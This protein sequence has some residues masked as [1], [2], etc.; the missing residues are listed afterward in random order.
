M[1]QEHIRNIA[2][3]FEGKTMRFSSASW[4]GLSWLLLQAL[5][6]RPRFRREPLLDSGLE[7]DILLHPAGIYFGFTQSKS[8]RVQS[9]LIATTTRQKKTFEITRKN[10]P[11]PI[12]E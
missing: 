10:E 5:C 1:F 2:L 8:Q 9:R 7:V 11:P 4:V 3:G 6:R 12:T